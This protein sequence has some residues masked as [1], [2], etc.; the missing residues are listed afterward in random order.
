MTCLV[1]KVEKKVAF[2]DLLKL[3]Y[4]VI[5]EYFLHPP[6]LILG[7]FCVFGGIALQK[8]AGSR[9][10]RLSPEM[11]FQIKKVAGERGLA[12]FLRLAAAVYLETIN[13][14]QEDTIKN[15]AN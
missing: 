9:S 14:Q 13:D 4:S 15:P 10:I 1:S 2:F 8:L 3:R 7:V 6:R 11:L 5:T 12:K